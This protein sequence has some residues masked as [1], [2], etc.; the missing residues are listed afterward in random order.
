[1]NKK[2]FFF[3]LIIT[4]FSFFIILQNCNKYQRIPTVFLDTVTVSENNSV[5]V[6][7]WIDIGENDITSYGLLL[8]DTNSNS[9]L[10]EISNS[11]T[12]GNFNFSFTIDS[13]RKKYSIKLYGKTIKNEFIYSEKILYFVAGKTLNICLGGS[14]EDKA[15]SIEQ[16]TD[17]GYIVAGYTDSNDGDVSGNHGYLDMWVVKLNANG[18]LNKN[19]K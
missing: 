7:G 16:T 14:D 9:Q 3:S 10:I 19:E 4:I 5:Q 11:A 17:G 12:S 2:I 18:E 8:T 6:S 13:L 1:M 15:Y